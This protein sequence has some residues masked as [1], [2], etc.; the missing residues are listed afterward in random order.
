[1]FK[2][3]QSTIEYF[4]FFA[5]VVAALIAMQTYIKRGMQGRLRSNFDQLTEGRMYSPGATIGYSCLTTNAIESSNSENKIIHSGTNIHLTVDRNE[6]V[7]SY[8]DEI[9]RW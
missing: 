6:E 1:M 3:G 9:Q 7:L 4:I 2:N 8:A 5:I